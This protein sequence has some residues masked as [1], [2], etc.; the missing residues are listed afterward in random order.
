MEAKEL[1]IGN[2]ILR[3]AFLPEN[4]NYHEIMVTH[5]DIEACVRNFADFKRIE[6]TEEWLIRFGGRKAD[7]RPPYDWNKN[8]EDENYDD[9]Y[10]SKEYDLNGV[11][12]EDFTDVVF[13]GHHMVAKNSNN[14]LYYFV[15]EV[16]GADENQYLVEISV[17]MGYVHTFQNY[18]PA[19]TGEE[20]T[21][22]TQ[23]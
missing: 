4:K 8:A 1:R 15:R 10:Y 18:Y 16:N 13:F 14:G 19:F 3:K 21:L 23:P 7:L 12:F 9:E 22:K 11:Y 5:H 6:L 20:L 17:S 2:S